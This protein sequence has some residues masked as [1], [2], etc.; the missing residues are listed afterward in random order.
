MKSSTQNHFL[1]FCFFLLQLNSS[2]S[3]RKEVVQKPGHEFNGSYT[4]QYLDRVAFPIGGLGAGMFCL[5]G[6]GSISHM[7]VRNKPEVF[8]EP[9]MFA[10]ISVKG[11]ENGAKVL[12]GPVPGWKRFGQPGSGNGSGGTTYGFPRFTDAE[13]T[14]RFPFAAIKLH[15]NDVPLDVVIT[16]WSPF[17]PTD[18]DN[19][20][21]PA[22]AIEYE[23]RNTGSAEIEAVFSY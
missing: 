6:T 13:F 7:S 12:E 16:G 21:L 11:V 2:C 5:E 23:F 19:S 4:G 15:D 9:C 17:I 18:P 1:L 8:N 14:A 20:G 22:G 10:A 3:E